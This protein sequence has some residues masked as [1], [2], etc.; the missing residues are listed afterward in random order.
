MR[1]SLFYRD[2]ERSEESGYERER[3]RGGRRVRKVSLVVD[4]DKDTTVIS[5]YC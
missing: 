2:R 3:E 4:Y 1:E 5:C